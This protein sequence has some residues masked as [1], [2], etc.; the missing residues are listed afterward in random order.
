MSGTSG[1]NAL[2]KAGN[3]LRA[4][5]PSPFTLAYGRRNGPKPRCVPLSSRL[6]EKIRPPPLLDFPLFREPIASSA[7][8]SRERNHQD[9]RHYHQPISRKDAIKGASEIFSSSSAALF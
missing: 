3:G 7:L 5:T 9:Y 2:G 4:R 8:R 1:E 6:G